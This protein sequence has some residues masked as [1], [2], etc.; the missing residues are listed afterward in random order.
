VKLIWTVGGSDP[1]C[2]ISP[3]AKLIDGLANVRAAA[4][5]ATQ[6]VEL[7]TIAPFELVLVTTA[8]CPGPD[9]GRR[10][11]DIDVA[12]HHLFRLWISNSRWK[13]DDLW[14]HRIPFIPL[15]QRKG[16]ADNR[17]MVTA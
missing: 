7:R 10:L 15:L 14:V 12:R 17:M 1:G 8:R 9:F 6:Q 3:A 5:T 16:G 4:R 2:E 11:Q 13:I